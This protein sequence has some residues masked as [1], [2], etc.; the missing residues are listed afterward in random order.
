MLKPL[1]SKGWKASAIRDE[2]IDG[3]PFSFISVSRE[4]GPP[5]MLLA[6]TF[7]DDRA[8]VVQVVDPNGDVE[9]TPELNAIVQSFRFLQ[10][11]H[12]VSRQDASTQSVAYQFGRLLGYLIIVVAVI[13]LIRKVFR[14]S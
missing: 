5:F 8:Y 6:A 12:S 14:R 3:K 7:A 13:F 1:T 2:A 10:P 11:V 4:T 9:K